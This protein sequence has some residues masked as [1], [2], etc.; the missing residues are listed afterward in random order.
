MQNCFIINTKA[1][2]SSKL[3]RLAEGLRSTSADFKIYR[4]KGPG[5]ATRFIR[6]Y[7]SEHPDEKIRFYACGGDGTLNEVVNGVVGFPNAEISAYPC[8]SGND[9]VKYYGAGRF[10]DIER[11]IKAEAHPVDLIKTGDR[12]SI[13]VVNCGFDTYACK[14][15]NQIKKKPIIG[16]KNAYYC[17]VAKS[18]VAAMKTEALVYADD[19]LL[20]EDG[21]MLLCS[22]ANGRYYGGSFMCAPLAENDDGLLEVCL[23]KPLSRVKFAT[24]VKAYENGEHLSD[25]RFAEYV[26]YRRCKKVQLQ[27]SEG[28]AVTIDGELVEGTEFTCEIIKGGIKFAAPDYKPE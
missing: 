21:S 28:F 5:D 17:G 7:C 6:K 2:R 23:V 18:V 3:K 16:G 20:N 15:M 12:Y 1:G 26:V 25:P 10:M 11:L 24:M 19:E 22:I 4:T 8:G 9:F 14:T 27:G 13:N